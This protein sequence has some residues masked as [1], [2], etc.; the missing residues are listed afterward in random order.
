MLGGRWVKEEG[1]GGCVGGVEKSTFCLAGLVAGYAW[2]FG[3]GGIG[4]GGGRELVG[5][6]FV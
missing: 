2:L 5:A 4:G 6:I 1:W 3:R